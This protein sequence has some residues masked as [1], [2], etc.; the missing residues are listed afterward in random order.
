MRGALWSEIS[1]RL[2]SQARGRELEAGDALREDVPFGVPCDAVGSPFPGPGFYGVNEHRGAVL[3][4]IRRMLQSFRRV[5][6]GWK[7]GK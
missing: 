4:L 7:Q 3:C 6:L 1:I 2:P 5:A